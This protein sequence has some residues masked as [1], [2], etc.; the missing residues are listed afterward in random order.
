[1]LELHDLSKRF[2]GFLA[3]DSVNLRVEAQHRHAIIGPNGAGKTTLFNL[4]TG[5]IAPS[6]GRVVFEGQD[7][8]GLRPHQLVRLGMG[9]SFQRINIYP[10]LSVFDNVQVARLA[11]HGRALSLFAPSRK[12]YRD[13]TMEILDLVHLAAEAEV[14]A[15]ELSYGRQKQIEL[16]VAL[17][18]EPRLLLLDEPTAGMSPPETRDAVRLIGRIAQARRLT[19]LFTEH[20]MDVVFEMA[21]VITVLHHGRVIASGPPEEVRSDRDVQRI[22]LGEILHAPA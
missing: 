18:L 15:G 8:T 6:A 2:A 17:A 22:Y 9:R 19:L 4:V 10:R 20:D 16:A 12:L 5:S 14:I 7:V 13:E 21:D 1:M 3:V 11:H